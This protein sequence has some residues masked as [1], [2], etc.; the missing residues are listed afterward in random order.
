MKEHV[1]EVCGKRLSKKKKFYGKILCSKHMHQFHKYGKFL[2][3]NSRT[4][5]DLNEYQDC[6]LITKGILYDGH[7][8]DPCAEFIIDTE[9]LYKVKYHKWRLSHNH[10]VTGLPAQG[11]QR[12]LSWVILGLDSRQHKDK[13]IDHVSGDPMDNRKVNLRM[14]SQGENMCNRRRHNNTSG[15]KGVT[16]RSDRGTYDP[17]IRRDDVR[18]HLGNTKS[19]E[20]GVFKRMVAERLVF[21]KFANR[22]Q[23][24]R[25]HNFSKDLPLR[26]KRE[27]AQAVVRKLR[28]KGLW[29]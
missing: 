14:C 1:C 26:R 2:D 16:Y 9:D 4:T 11:T 20:E 8:S 18:C 19:L 21:G 6:G 24:D 23:Q 17:D 25:Y 13:V 15:F 27:L 7:T 22:Y 29:Q 12:E 10:V 28:N 5:K 3:T